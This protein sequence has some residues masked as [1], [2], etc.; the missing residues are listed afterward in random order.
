MNGRRF[1]N[2]SGLVECRP[3]RVEEPADLAAIARAV[4]ESADAGS[5]C[6]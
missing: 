3:A 5:P 2:W 1:R 4:R 6:G